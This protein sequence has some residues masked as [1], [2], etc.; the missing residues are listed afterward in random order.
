MPGG[1]GI[2]LP[3]VR[4][5]DLQAAGIASAYGSRAGAVG[6]QCLKLRLHFNNLVKSQDRA[7]AREGAPGETS[8]T[9]RAE[10]KRKP[11]LRVDASPV[12]APWRRHRQ[13]RPHRLPRG[14]VAASHPASAVHQRPRGSIC[15]RL[16]RSRLAAALS[17]R[18]RPRRLAALWG[19]GVR[20]AACPHVLERP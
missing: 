16:R 18:S 10:K 19:M 17:A 15:S 20:S 8:T 11:A 3:P 12:N 9:T 4:S 1:L 5:G 6:P 14:A 2:A 13:H 7:G